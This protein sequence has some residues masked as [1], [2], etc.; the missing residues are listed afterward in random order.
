MVDVKKKATKEMV[1]WYAEFTKENNDRYQSYTADQNKFNKAKTDLTNA[2]IGYGKA[3]QVATEELEKIKSNQPINYQSKSPYIEFQ[4]KFG[5]NM[6][7]YKL[8]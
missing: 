4:N 1:K 3:L 5:E 7:D 8:Y 2:I 6:T